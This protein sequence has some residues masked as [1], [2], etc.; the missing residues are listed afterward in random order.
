MDSDTY[1]IALFFHLLGAL[2]FVAGIVLAGA[3]FEAARRREQPAEVALLLTLTRIGV[4]LVA[5][6]GLLL[7]IFGL[8]MVHLG[9]WGFG[10]GWVDWA[11][12]LYVIALVL[13][14]LGGQRPKQARNLASRLAAEN[15]PVNDELR[16]LLNDRVSLAENYA[17]LL[18]V[19]AI[20]VLMV[21]KP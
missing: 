10:S 6:G 21:F 8:W 20:L 2:M 4:V 18:T 9:N 3:A 15:A 11:L 1:N 5:L 16:A 19:L 7:P 13:G 14:G 17:S 12:G